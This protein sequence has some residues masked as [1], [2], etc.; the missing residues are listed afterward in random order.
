MLG[1]L[2]KQSFV[3]W[4]AEEVEIYCDP[5]ELFAGLLKGPPY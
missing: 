4:Q 5:A 1:S 2:G 3:Y